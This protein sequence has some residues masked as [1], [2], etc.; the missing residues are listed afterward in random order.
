MKKVLYSVLALATSAKEVVHPAPVHGLVEK[1]QPVSDA[2]H[3]RMVQAMKDK[4]EYWTEHQA[5]GEYLKYESVLDQRVTCPGGDSGGSISAGGTSY[6]CRNIDFESFISLSQLSISGNGGTSAGSDIWGWRSSTGREITLMCVDNGMWFIDSTNPSSPARLGFMRSGRPKAAWC[7]VKVYQ[8]TAYVVKDGSGASTYGVE[9]FDLNRLNSVTGD[10]LISFSPD[11]VYSEHGASHNIAINTQTGYAYSVGSNTCSGGLHMIDLSNRLAPQFAGCVSGDGYTHDVECIVYDG[12]DSRYTGRE[13]CFASNEDTLTIWDVTSK[14][15][16]TL[17]SR[18]GYSGS[19]YSHQSWLTDDR[20]YVLLNDELDESG[21]SVSRTTTYIADVSSLTSV[22]FVN[23]FVS[24]ETSPDHNLYVWGAIHRRGQGGN[25]A[26]SNPPSA[27]YAY[28]SNY[29]AGIRVLD[30][31]NLPSANEVG[32][33]DVAPNI[34]GTTFDGTW[35]NY[36]HPSGTLAVSSID[37]G[38]FFL[39]P[40]MAFGG[41]FGGGTPT[42]PLPTPFPSAGPD[43]VDLSP[44][45]ITV[46]GVPTECPDLVIYCSGYDF[47]RE[48]CPLSCGECGLVTLAADNGE[49]IEIPV[50]EEGSDLVYY[51]AIGVLGS[52]ATALAVM[53]AVKNRKNKLQVKQ[54]SV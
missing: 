20:R 3:M 43:C 2:A 21:G 6:P 28:L 39:T 38:L 4:E 36:M 26:L 1:N 17:L 15:S 24:T 33:F 46:G 42:T 35:S 18:T 34:G 9:V 13:I 10:A 54:I 14:S 8:N 23:T 50:Q 49:V 31:S 29:V 32:Y 30:I 52:V 22:S 40:R 53:L 25:G 51:L 16:P 27:D 11:F 19:R 41:D 44:S 47:V 5:S 45:G 7:D 48:R 12:P 37:R